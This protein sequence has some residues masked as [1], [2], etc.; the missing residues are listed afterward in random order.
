[1][2][3]SSWLILAATTTVV[4]ASSAD[5]S[6]SQ[7]ECN[8]DDNDSPSAEKRFSIKTRVDSFTMSS[9][10]FQLDYREFCPYLCLTDAAFK[11]SYVRGDY[12]G[13]NTGN[14]E[15]LSYIQAE[16][17]QAWCLTVA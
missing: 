13:F 8:F 4:L 2:T 11:R 5:A 12:V 14:G 15:K 16:P 9:K 10:K 7:L 3:L 1:M 17:G 6:K